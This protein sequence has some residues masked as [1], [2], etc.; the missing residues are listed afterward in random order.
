[1]PRCSKCS[2]RHKCRNLCE[3]VEK[4]ITGR[5]KT[6]SQKPRTYPV[7]FTLIEDNRQ[8]LNPF[9][10]EVL[11]DLVKISPDMCERIII[12]LT[13]QQAV[14]KVLTAK[15]KE[16]FR[17]FRENYEQKNIAVILGITQPRVNVLL[18]RVLKKL[19][20]FMM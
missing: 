7:D 9:Q 5:G 2:N 17:L 16:L 14:D 8:A 13:L 10:K 4:L 15:E 12:N 19:R 11:Q 3:A 18:K 20:N 1:M 6:A